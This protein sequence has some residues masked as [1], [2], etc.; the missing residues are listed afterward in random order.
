[1]DVIPGIKPS[2]KPS[3]KVSILSEPLGPPLSA[4]KPPEFSFPE[5]IS[6]FHYVHLQEWQESKEEEVITAGKTSPCDFDFPQIG[7]PSKFPKDDAA[8]A[9]C[10]GWHVAGSASQLCCKRVF[11]RGEAPDAAIP[12]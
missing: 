8:W 11:H 2:I 7:L 5:F 4:H 6:S 3:I 10:S 9:C 12:T 1:M